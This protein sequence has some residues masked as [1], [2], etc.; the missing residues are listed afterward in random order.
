M[1]KIEQF[2]DPDLSLWQSAVDEV[3]AKKTGSTRSQDI[4]GSGAVMRPDTG[5]SMVRGAAVDLTAEDSGAPLQP[6]VTVGPS[7]TEGFG[8]MAKFCSTVARKL[9]WATVTGN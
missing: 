8:D 1:A 3:V 5:N 2:R 6:P 4:G 9:A 7:A